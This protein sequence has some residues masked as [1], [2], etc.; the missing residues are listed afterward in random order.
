VGLCCFA[1]VFVGLGVI[2]LYHVQVSPTPENFTFIKFYKDCYFREGIVELLVLSKWCIQKG[3]NF[4][5]I[6]EGSGFLIIT[7]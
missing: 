3:Q 5:Y 6:V 4:L 2:E 1:F 7:Q